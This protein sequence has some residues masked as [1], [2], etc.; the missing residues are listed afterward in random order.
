MLAAVKA[1]AHKAL[2]HMGYDLINVRT[3]RPV[4]VGSERVLG[5]YPPLG[6]WCRVGTSSNYFIHD[7]YRHRL[8]VP[9]YD[10]TGNDHLW[11]WEVYQFAREI[12]DRERFHSVCDIGCGSGHKLMKYFQDLTT[13]GIE[14]AET[15]GYLHKRWPNR[16]WMIAGPDAV[17]P[18]PVEMVIAADVIEHLRD[19]DQLLLSIEKLASRYIVISTPDRNLLRFG[20]HDG[21]PLNPT[22][23]REWNFAEFQA[24]VESWFDIEEHFISFAAQA[25]QCILCKPRQTQRPG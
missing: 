16:H 1:L 19:P 10:A 22:H 9:S 12:C 4:H 3:S 7:G 20:T 11:Q 25:T 5:S 13:V 21:P 8:E 6:T 2:R 15:C 14:V 18:F 17:P 23:T 24:Y